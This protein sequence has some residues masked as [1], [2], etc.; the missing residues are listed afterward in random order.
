V[1]IP[2]EELPADYFDELYYELCQVIDEF[3]FMGDE[4]KEALKLEVRAFLDEL[5][6]EWNELV[7]VLNDELPEFMDVE[8][9]GWPFE[10]VLN[11]LLDGESPW[12]GSIDTETGQFT[13]LPVIL[14]CG[15]VPTPFGQ[16]AA[17][18][19]A[20]VDGTLHPQQG[21]GEGYLFMEWELAVVSP[22]YV[23]MF[24]VG[25]NGSWHGDLT[26][27]E[28]SSNHSSRAVVE[29]KDYADQAFETMMHDLS[30]PFGQ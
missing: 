25:I 18:S 29:V 19:V 17:A 27:Y 24:G 13:L 12:A 6:A 21:Y 2:A 8:Q 9:G 7:F 14:P 10:W 30:L 11:I 16:A 22:A 20:M 5:L 1:N 4:E 23:F 3:P 28:T 15:F 26:S